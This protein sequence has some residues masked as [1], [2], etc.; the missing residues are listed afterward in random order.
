M[1]KKKVLV[2][3]DDRDISELI[4]YN[5]KR[6]DYDIV[7]LY[8]GSNV[9][10][11]VRKRKPDLIILDLMLPGVGGLEICRTLKNDPA[12]KMIPIIMLT[13]K[14]EEADVVIGLQMGADDYITKPFSPSILAAR[15]KSI[16]HRMSDVKKSLKKPSRETKE[17]HVKDQMITD[18]GNYCIP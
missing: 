13:A 10:E 5:L 3:E 2:V 17:I 9:I 8:D 11:F 1:V 12:T 14:G 18:V 16:T 15:I 4:A 7:C 6:E